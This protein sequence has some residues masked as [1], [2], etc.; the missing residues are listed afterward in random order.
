MNVK[1]KTNTLPW[2]LIVSLGLFALIRPIV[3][4]LG[5]VFGYEVSSLATMAITVVIALVWVVMVI[6][7]KVKKPVHVLALSGIVYAVSSILMAATIQLLAPDL[8]NDE[9][10][11][12]TLLTVGLVATTAFNFAYGAFLGF[13]AMTLQKVVNS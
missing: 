9:A 1:Q 12:S 2:T 6:K 13:I 10:K 8:G 3:K 7:L 5:D 11:I 4:I